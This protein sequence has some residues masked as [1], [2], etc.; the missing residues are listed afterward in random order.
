[1]P[2]GIRDS[3]PNARRTIRSTKPHEVSAPLDSTGKRSSCVWDWQWS[4]PAPRLRGILSSSAS[5]P[6]LS[7][8]VFDTGPQL[9]DS[10]LLM[11]SNRPKIRHRWCILSAFFQRRTGFGYC[12]KANSMMSGV[13]IYRA[14]RVQMRETGFTIWDY[15]LPL[16]EDESS[17]DVSVSHGKSPYAP[18]EQRKSRTASNGGQ[19]PAPVVPRCLELWIRRPSRVTPYIVSTS[20]LWVGKVW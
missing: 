20:A 3:G 11:A 1:M 2:G 13:M 9:M 15:A 19:K 18:N 16:I 6:Y 4:I 12:A 14:V 10:I 17:S 7:S 5:G 8:K